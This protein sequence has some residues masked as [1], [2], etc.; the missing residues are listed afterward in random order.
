MNKYQRINLNV[1]V[2][3]GDILSEIDFDDVMQW[4]EI[5]MGKSEFQDWLRDYAR[6]ELNMIEK[7]EE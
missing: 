1:D 2:R 5:D 3:I 4:Y 7:E 6:E